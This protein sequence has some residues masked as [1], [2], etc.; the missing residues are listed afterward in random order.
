MLSSLTIQQHFEEYPYEKHLNFTENLINLIHSLSLS[1]IQ[2]KNRSV[3][4]ILMFS[5]VYLYW[6]FPITENENKPCKI[7]ILNQT[8]K[9]HFQS[10]FVLCPLTPLV[11]CLSLSLRVVDTCYN[12]ATYLALCVQDSLDKVVSPTCD[13]FALEALPQWNVIMR[14]RQ[15]VCKNTSDIWTF[16]MYLSNEKYI[17]V[18]PCFYN[19]FSSS[20][21]NIL[22]IVENQY[23]YTVQQISVIFEMKK[24][25]V[26]NIILWCCLCLI[27]CDQSL[28]LLCCSEAMSTGTA[29]SPKNYFF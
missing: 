17:N 10:V 27:T 23:S 15:S 3:M 7:R 14:T 21:G 16:Q 19:F 5:S 18:R 20:L 13:I 22:S 9:K 6:R 1:D 4:H 26:W 28:Q 11:P 8:N 12:W 25:S 2:Y 29:G 24:N